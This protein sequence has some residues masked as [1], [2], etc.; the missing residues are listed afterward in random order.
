MYSVASR[1]PTSYGFLDDCWLNN[2]LMFLCYASSSLLEDCLWEYW[3]RVVLV[4]NSENFASSCR[5]YKVGRLAVIHTCMHTYIHTYIHTC[6]Y[7]MTRFLRN[8]GISLHDFCPIIR[9]H[10]SGG[11]VART[12]ENRLPLLVFQYHP[13][14]CRDLGRP[15]Q[16]GNTKIFFK[17]KRKSNQRIWNSTV[18]DDG[19]GAGGGCDDDASS[20]MTIFSRLGT[21]QII[22]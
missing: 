4:V 1:R 9:L 17:I 15:Q 11:R 12:E 2:Y 18:H 19:G 7:L 14:G 6:L 16:N 3:E 22:L 8:S 10:G 5:S 21:L 13:T 20:Y